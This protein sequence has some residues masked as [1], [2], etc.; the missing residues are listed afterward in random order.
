MEVFFQP[1]AGAGDEK[2]GNDA[3]AAGD[4]GN[5]PESNGRELGMA[6]KGR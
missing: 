2:N 3:A 6:D 4:E 5:V 1:S